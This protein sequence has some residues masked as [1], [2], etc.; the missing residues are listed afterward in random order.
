MVQSF[1]IAIKFRGKKKPCKLTHLSFIGK[2]NF[3]FYF[4]SS[5]P[6]SGHSTL[7]GAGNG[8]FLKSSSTGRF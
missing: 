7:E 1:A 3:L 5:S 8:L 2:L 6:K 4:V